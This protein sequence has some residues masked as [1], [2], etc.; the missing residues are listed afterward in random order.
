MTLVLER[1]DL[2][3][4]LR[5]FCADHPVFGTCAGSI[6]LGRQGNDR[7]VRSFGH[8]DIATER[9]AYGRQVDS[10]TAS[11]SIESMLEEPFHAVF[12]RAPHIVETGPGVDILATYENMPILVRQN[13]L[14]AATFH[15][16][17]SADP[18]IHEYFI[19][20]VSA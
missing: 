15:P 11:V 13:Q 18:R 14:L 16:E 2:W 6:L 1:E 4:P 7:R 12:I 3:E 8:L 19:K 10:F 17:L 9:N 20:M 5:S